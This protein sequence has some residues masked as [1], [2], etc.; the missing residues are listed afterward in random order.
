MGNSKLK[1]QNLKVEK[2]GNRNLYTFNL[3][4]LTFHFY[5]GGGNGKNSRD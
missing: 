5:C 1:S 3:L 4:L 2:K